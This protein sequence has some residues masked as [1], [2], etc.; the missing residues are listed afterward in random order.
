MPLA[1]PVSHPANSVLPSTFGPSLSLMKRL[2]VN[3]DDFGFTSGTNAGILRAHKEG[4]LTSTTI[5][6]NGP[7]FDEA[8]GIALANPRL[9]VG[10][11]ISIVD[12]D[13]VCPAAEIPSLAGPDGRLPRTV[14]ELAWKLGRSVR[15]RDVEREIGA[16]IQRVRG[17]GITP[18]HLDT[19]KHSHLHPAILRALAGAA[20]DFGIRRIRRPYERVALTVAGRAARAQRAVHLKQWASSIVSLSTAPFFNATVHRLRITTPERFYGIALTGLLDTAAVLQLLAMVGDGTVEL[21]CHP[22]VHDGELDRARTR[23]KESREAELAALTDP[24]VRRAVDELGIRLI[25][26]RDL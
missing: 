19:H 18:T 11:H 5:M 15:I 21:M 10:C 23:L 1:R 22:G 3:G 13:P 8:A 12:G 25:D 20:G 9:G 4:I 7:A 17:A 6:A 2:I 24:G 14:V 26:Y 16:Q